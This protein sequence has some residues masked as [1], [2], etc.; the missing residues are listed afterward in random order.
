MEAAGNREKQ[1]PV[2]CGPK[3]F[4][5]F[6]KLLGLQDVQQ[7]AQPEAVPSLRDWL[8]ACG[9]MAPMDKQVV[10]VVVVVA[11]VLLCCCCCCCLGVLVPACLVLLAQ[12]IETRD[13]S[14]GNHELMDYPENQ[15]L[16]LVLNLQGVV[17]KY[18]YIFVYIYICIYTYLNT[19]FL[20]MQQKLYIPPEN[21][22]DDGQKQKYIYIYLLYI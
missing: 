7:E 1:I 6:P 17:Y 8:V 3:R 11:W 21:E 10:V 2:P 22:H 18:I 19:H 15:P 12:P 16:Y 9:N 14:W 20:K 5:I 13:A 4:R